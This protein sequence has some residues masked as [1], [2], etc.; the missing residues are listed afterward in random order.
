MAEEPVAPGSPFMTTAEAARRL[1]VRPAT[2]YAYVSRGMI[3]SHRV[4]GEKESRFARRDVERLAARTRA[5]GRAAA[6][7]VVVDTELTLLDPAGHLYYRGWDAVDACTTASFEQVAEW[8]WT[9][10]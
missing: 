6:L 9:G 7:E 8:L 2:L 3:E 4:A 5:G 10:A 1:G